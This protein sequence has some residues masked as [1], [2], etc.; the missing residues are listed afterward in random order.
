MLN[1]T[2][3]KASR[4]FVA[5]GALLAVAACSQAPTEYEADVKDESGGQLIVSDAN[6]TDV[7]VNVPTTP[8]T[9]VPP[10]EPATAM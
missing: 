4:T 8:M 5:I 9:N 10:S 2:S 7:P 1:T 6:S 3:R